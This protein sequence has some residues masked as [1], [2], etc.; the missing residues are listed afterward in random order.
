MLDL[1]SHHLE[2]QPVDSLNKLIKA[3]NSN[4]GAM[5]T[6]GGKI[7]SAMSK[8]PKV[9]KSVMK[10]KPKVSSKKMSKGIKR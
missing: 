1:I 4:G 7:K 6:K 10:E 9:G 2:L 8:M 5:K 3:Q